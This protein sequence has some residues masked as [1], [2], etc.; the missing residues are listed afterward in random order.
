MMVESQET[1][2]LIVKLGEVC[3]A[4]ELPAP[5][6]LAAVSML[7]AIIGFKYGITKEGVLSGMKNI[8]NGVYEDLQ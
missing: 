8:L 3:D 6:E 1:K 5:K 7:L 4:A 2:D